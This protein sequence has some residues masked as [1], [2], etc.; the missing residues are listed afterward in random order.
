MTKRSSSRLSS[1][2]SQPRNANE[3]RSRRS[4]LQNSS[5]RRRANSAFAVKN[6][7]MIA[8]KLYEGIELGSEGSVGLITYMRTD[9]TRVSR[10]CARRSA[11]LHRPAVRRPTICRKKPFIIARRKTRRMR[12]KRFVHRSCAHAESL[13]QFLK[14]EEL[15]LY[16]LIWQRFVAS[17]MMRGDLRPDHDRH[18]RRTLRVPRYRFGAE[19]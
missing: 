11:R 7:M 5:R 10:S 14:P 13:A 19:V 4:S 8:Q 1:Q 3:I 2:K 6:T 16:R 17:Q 15:K 9:S 12:T 18:Q